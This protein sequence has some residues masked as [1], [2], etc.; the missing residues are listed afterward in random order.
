MLEIVVSSEHKA[1]VY[2][3]HMMIL[4]CLGKK[5]NPVSW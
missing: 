1:S 5:N 4:K 3:K 2:L